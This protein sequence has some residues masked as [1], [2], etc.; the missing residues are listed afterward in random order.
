VLSRRG[1]TAVAL[2][3]CLAVGGSLRV[4]PTDAARDGAGATTTIRYLV[5]VFQEN[6]SF[7]HYFATYPQAANPPGEP[8]FRAAPRTPAVDNLLRAGL[9]A[10]NNPNAA[11]P[12]RLARSRAATCDQNHA[13]WAEQ[14]AAHGG[15]M[16]LFVPFV[17][18]GSTRSRPC[19]DYGLGRRLV[20][21]YF[22]GN[23]VTALWNYAQ[24]FAMSDRFFNTTFGPST[25]GALNL[26]TGQTHGASPASLR[27]PTG[28]AVAAGSMV[29]DGQP[30]FD[31]CSMLPVTMAM[32]GRN[33]GDL[34]NARGVTWG[35][36]EGGFAP[37]S[38]VRGTARCHTA[39]VG[40]DG[41]LK[42]DYLPHH[43]P[44]QYYASTA[45]PH[46]LPPS[47]VAMIGR[48]DRAN[49]QYDLRDFWAAAAAGTIPAVSYLKAPAYADG[50]AGYSS[51]LAEQ[52]FIV[53]T[54]N[55]LQQLPQW[56]QMAV[57]VTYDDSD[58]WYDHVAGPI[59][60]H[61]QTSVDAAIC[62][63]AAPA[64]GAYQGRCGYGPRLPLLVISPFARPSYVDHTLTDQSSILRFIEDN[65]ELGRI[66]D[67]S[68]D[69]VAGSL[70]GL[71]DFDRPEA[72]RLF[73]DPDTGLPLPGARPE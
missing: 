40:S 19:H 8:A 17:G 27:L 67:R 4:G 57:I 69:E 12:F 43:E 71:F 38:V 32:S 44:F 14:A 11:Q 37:S 21:G 35:W 42:E 24:H 50:H 13:Y 36:F 34:L 20:M 15:A 62:T 39:H 25:P 41:T 10:P 70:L 60:N 45:N 5:V 23:T 7:D 55:R 68:F 26:I 73:L 58:G 18:V 33:V 52:R 51:P 9:L 49:H 63:G 6:V 1:A 53:E 59:V 2:V 29:G 28:P 56:R 72:G 47:S 46:H 31:D 48:P 64:L 54:L 65:W 3:A 66:G 22:D 16:D 61:S 30:R